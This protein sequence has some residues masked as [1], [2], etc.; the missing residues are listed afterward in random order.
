MGLM[1][2]VGLIGCGAVAKYGHLPSIVRTQGLVLTSLMDVDEQ[3][4]SDVKAR[5][6]AQQT[7]TDLAR[8]MHSGIDAVVVTSPAPNHKEHVLAA[9]ELRKP[10]LCEKP[11]AMTESDSQVMIDAM[12][13]A[14]MSLH[15][16]F[17]YR[18]SPAA[19]QIHRL[20]SEGKIGQLKDLRLIYNWDCHGT[21]EP[22]TGTD[23]NQRR[24]GRMNEG[25]PMVDCGVHQI[26][27]ARWWV[28]AEVRSVRPI[29]V[30]IEKHAAP[31]HMYLHMDH[32]NGAHTLV[33]I[34]YSYGHTAREPRCQFVYE[35]IGTE[36]IIRY[37]R[38]TRLFEL[39]NRDGTTELQWT[40]EKNFDGMYQQWE[41]ALRTGDAG[42]MPTGSDGLMATRLARTATDD[43]IAQGP[44]RP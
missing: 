43:L 33:E 27:L 38:E 9:A 40:P 1:I 15:V 30:W 24:L 35:L 6:G 29:G 36:G 42:T 22:R 12:R 11:L 37:H 23:I 8:F 16:G 20:L 4:L 3:R 25:G 41:T 21:F 32:E 28:G 31:D 39:V 13:A 18:F 26:D 17:T 7:Y 34:S 19:Q 2:R 44:H 10:V 5:F 14:G